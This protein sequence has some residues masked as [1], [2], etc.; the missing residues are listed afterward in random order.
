MEINMGSNVLRDTNG[1]L[2]VEG[3][4]QVLFEIDPHP[5]LLLTMDVYDMKGINVAKVVRNKFSFDY[6]DRY[7]MIAKPS[8]LMLIDRE[9]NTV[10]LEAS[11]L[12]TNNK[13]VQVL[14]GNFYSSKG[15]PIEITPRCWRVMGTTIG[16]TTFDC[17]GGAVYIGT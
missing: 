8:S 1:V 7:R 2:N 16:G 5:Q 3:K 4:D 6:K 14:R 15:H 9:H 17:H 12:D 10:L 11:V 13:K